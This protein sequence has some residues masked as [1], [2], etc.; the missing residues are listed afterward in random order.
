MRSRSHR[1]PGPRCR[2]LFLDEPEAADA[3]KKARLAIAESAG[4]VTLAAALQLP[5]IGQL[6]EGLRPAV[7]RTR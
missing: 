7:V 6:L 1:F 4:E 2:A 5:E 3:V